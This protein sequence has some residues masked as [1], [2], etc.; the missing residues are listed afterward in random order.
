MARN[1][2]LIHTEFLKIRSLADDRANDC[3]LLAVCVHTKVR[4]RMEVF[5]FFLNYD[6]AFPL[7][8]KI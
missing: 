5:I 6:I 3:D 1:H 2:H 8:D 7:L 4:T